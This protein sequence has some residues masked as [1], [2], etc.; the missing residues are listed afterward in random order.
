MVPRLILVKKFASASFDFDDSSKSSTVI[1]TISPN[2]FASKWTSTVGEGLQLVFA[3]D[4]THQWM[5]YLDLI[6]LQPQYR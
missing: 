5:I 1:L 4:V 6:R 2:L 3:D